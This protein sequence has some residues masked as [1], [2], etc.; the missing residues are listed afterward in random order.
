M[1][2]GGFFW[3]VFLPVVV[4]LELFVSSPSRTILDLYLLDIGLPIWHA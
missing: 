4:G 2:F 3:C 1:I